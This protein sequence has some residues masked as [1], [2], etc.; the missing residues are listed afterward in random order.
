MRICFGECMKGMSVF[1]IV[2]IMYSSIVFAA[3]AEMPREHPDGIYVDASQDTPMSV[4]PILHEKKKKYAIESCKH[5]MQCFERL[6]HASYFGHHKKVR[7]YVEDYKIDINERTKTGQTSLMLASLGGNIEIVRY[8]CMMGA[9]VT[10]QNNDYYTARMLAAMVGHVPVATFLTQREAQINPD[11]EQIDQEVFICKLL[12]SVQDETVK[13]MQS[14]GQNKLGK[15][16]VSRYG[17]VW[18]E[19]GPLLAASFTK[20]SKMSKEQALKKNVVPMQYDKTGVDIFSAA[21]QGN[22]EAIKYLLDTKKVD[23]NSQDGQ[24][25]TVLMEASLLGKDHIV[26]YLIE[27]KADLT[28]CDE[29]KQS[30]LMFALVGGCSS[31]VQQLLS[32]G[33]EVNLEGKKGVTPFLLAVMSGK[34]ELVKMLIMRGAKCDIVDHY[35]RSPLHWALLMCSRDMQEHNGF[36]G[37]DSEIEP[38]VNLLIGC[39][40]SVVYPDSNGCTPLYF[41][42]LYAPTSVYKILFVQQCIEQS[43]LPQIEGPAIKK[44]DAKSSAVVVFAGQAELKSSVVPLPSIFPTSQS[45]TF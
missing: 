33:A 18:P 26:Q 45:S 29:H 37:H 12:L 8:L 32:A 25:R 11:V 39:G 36:K 28:I 17:G 19:V 24:K 43:K 4:A 38:I 27:K 5:Y 42:A 22:L 34:Y 9:S 15:E 35:G 7:K 2:M 44:D 41:A 6:L 20:N 1:F 3:A 30:A 14:F 23:V 40:I 10:R 16:L 31:I 21:R 13:T